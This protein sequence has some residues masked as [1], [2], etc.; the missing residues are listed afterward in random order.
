MPQ[1]FKYLSNSYLSV[2][3][4]TADAGEIPCVRRAVLCGSGLGAL[5]AKTLA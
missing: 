2:K 1:M 4:H 5:L 3:L